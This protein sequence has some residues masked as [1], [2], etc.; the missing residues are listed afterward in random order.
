[1]AKRPRKAQKKRHLI[2]ETFDSDNTKQLLLNTAKKLFAEKGFEGTTVKDISDHAG[3][4]IS[5]VSY[6][7]SGKKG[8]YRACLHEFGRERLESAQKVLVAPQSFEEFRVRVQLFIEEIIQWMIKNPE[9]C[10]MVQREMDLGLPMAED[11]FSSTFL[12][13]HS[14]LC[15]FFEVSKSRHFIRRDVDLQV[16]ASM[17]M[18]AIVHLVRN[19]RIGE[20]FFGLTLRDETY[21]KKVKQQILSLFLNGFTGEPREGE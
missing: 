2:T 4:N 17:F 5:L 16:G 3:V 6:H 7:Y 12:E 8:L 1:M 9:S 14:T 19:D 18:A 13:V 11:V 10:Q 20:K 15:K 21:R